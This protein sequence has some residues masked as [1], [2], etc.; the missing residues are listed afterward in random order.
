MTELKAGDYCIYVG[1]GAN[2]K[3]VHLVTEIEKIGDEIFVA[4][5]GSIENSWYGPLIDFLHQ[6][7]QK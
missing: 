2:S 7:K 6:F 5:W 3:E 1:H 4:T